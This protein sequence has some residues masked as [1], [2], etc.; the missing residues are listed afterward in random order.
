MPLIDYTPE[1]IEARKA[2]LR[3]QIKEKQEALFKKANGLT[4]SEAAE[5]TSQ[6]WINNIGKAIAIYDGLMTGYKIYRGVRAFS[7]LPWKKRRKKR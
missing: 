7:F 5:T 2:E 3:Q 4:Q 6:K 1:S